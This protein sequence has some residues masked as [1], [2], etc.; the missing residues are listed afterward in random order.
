VFHLFHTHYGPKNHRTALLT[1][2][3]LVLLGPALFA[4]GSQID[5]AP[6]Q[7]APETERGSVVAVRT[8][9]PAVVIPE[10]QSAPGRGTGTSSTPVVPVAS[11]TRFCNTCLDVTDSLDM[12]PPLDQTGNEPTDQTA[13]AFDDADATA[14]DLSPDVAYDRD[15]DRELVGSPEAD[16]AQGDEESPSPFTAGPSDSDA[17]PAKKSA[18][19]DEAK[20]A[21]PR[22]DGAKKKVVA[23]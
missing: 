23:V 10:Q 19:G 8:I 17:K 20:K 16:D 15:I 3:A 4:Y 11:K 5:K 12:E 1:S 14:P 7:Q 21:P 18:D 2:V 9:V 13:D 6:T 22:A